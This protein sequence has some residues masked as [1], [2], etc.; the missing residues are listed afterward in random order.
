MWSRL[1]NKQPRETPSAIRRRMERVLADL[2][3]DFSAFSLEDFV[4]WLAE[5]SGETLRLVAVPFPPQ[6]FGL[7]ITGQAPSVE[8]FLY[9]AALAPHH[10]VHVALHEISHWLCQ[11]KTIVSPTARIEE[12]IEALSSGR[13]VGD[14]LEGVSLRAESARNPDE[15][16][17]AEALALLI[18]EAVMRA[19]SRAS[20]E[21]DPNRSSQRFID[22]MGLD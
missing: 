22:S 7:W 4:D 5:G 1:F 9:D 13:D 15:E 12:M 11:H 20:A 6:I 3:Y 16:H 8:Y 21:D 10:Q 2:D 19:R 18:E 14:L 17:E